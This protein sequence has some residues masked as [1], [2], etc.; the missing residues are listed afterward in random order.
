M[1]RHTLSQTDLQSGELGRGSRVLMSNTL[2]AWWGRGST[3]AGP[4]AP[5][6]THRWVYGLWDL[7]RQQR[8]IPF[9]AA[10]GEAA[11]W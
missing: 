7:P 1:S 8:S 2:E 10:P 5:Q 11:S 9:P 4:Q 3:Q 6:G